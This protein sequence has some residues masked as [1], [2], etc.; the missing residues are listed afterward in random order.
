MY[1]SH[2]HHIPGTEYTEPT[3][4][5]KARCG[6]VGLCKECTKDAD[7]RFP[8]WR[9][10]V[11]KIAET[12]FFDV[13]TYLELRA[14]RTMSDGEIHNR[15]GYHQGTANSQPV[16]AELRRRF[17]EFVTFLDRTLP[18]G[19]AKDVALT[20]LETTAM[21]SHKA[22]AETDPIVVEAPSLD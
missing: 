21:W 7:V 11:G 16:H 15:F 9:D 20:E 3:P 18:K 4:N 22:V 14:R 8:L 17:I 1:T 13:D 19:R 5:T 10:F 2:G 6:A 12:V